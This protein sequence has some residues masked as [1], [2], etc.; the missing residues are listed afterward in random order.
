MLFMFV[1]HQQ[2]S[3]GAHS[4]GRDVPTQEAQY[5][6]L[7]QAFAWVFVGIPLDTESLRLSAQPRGT[8]P[9]MEQ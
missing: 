8:F 2:T 1:T 6:H 7:L 4:S 3:P 5:A 9:G